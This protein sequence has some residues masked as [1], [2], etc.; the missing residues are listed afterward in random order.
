M[1]KQGDAEQPR[2]PVSQTTAKTADTAPTGSTPRED[3]IAGKPFGLR[4]L[5]R[6]LGTFA[7]GVTIVT[8]RDADGRPV[9]MTAN[10]FNSVSLEPPLVLWSVDRS[11]RSAAAFRA[12]THFAVHVLEEGQADLSNRF[13]RKGDDKFA[14][15]D[16][17]EG[18]GGVPLLSGALA[19]FECRTQAV[20]EGGDHEIIVGE[21]DRFEAH[22]GDG[23]VFAAGGY[24]TAEPLRPMG[25]QT[26]N[27]AD[28]DAPVE[29]LLL[30][31]LARATRAMSDG[32]HDAVREAGLTVPQWR[33]LASVTRSN[34]SFGDLADRSFVNSAALTDMLEGFERDG[35]VQVDRSGEQWR[36]SGTQRGEERIAHLF[37]LGA[38][39]E[40]HALADAPEGALETLIDMLRRVVANSER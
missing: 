13:A 35:L 23:L 34:R 32:F 29:A 10:S 33:V 1:N 9:G 38:K 16:W 25:P 4:A 21:V 8:A 12:A 39:Q 6:A 5:R 18:E 31:H 19:V 37:A 22:D 26:A 3:A 14:G 15:L 40:R 27:G 7:T 20:H 11:A 36:V 2:A 24:A 28:G 30:Y 17:R